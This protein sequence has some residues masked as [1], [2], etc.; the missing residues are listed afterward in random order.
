MNAQKRILLL[1]G[2]SLLAEA[3]QNILGPLEGVEVVGPWVPEAATLERLG[4]EEPGDVFDLIL[5]ADSRGESEAAL[6]GQMM[7][8][9]PD[10]PVARIG[11]DDN[12][13]HLYT[14]R[15]PGPSR[16]SD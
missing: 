11:L 13:I 6:V 14:A 10:L 9:Y 1:C 7:E 5:I 15:A 16:R 12:V 4:P 3:L 8:Q 2:Q